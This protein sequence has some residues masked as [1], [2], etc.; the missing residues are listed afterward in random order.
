MPNVHLHG[1]QADIYRFMYKSHVVI[2]PSFSEGTPRSLVEAMASARPVI[3][4]KVGGIPFIVSNDS[5]GYLVPPG[6]SYS[7]SRAIKMFL[8]NPHSVCDF[9]LRARTL[10]LERHDIKKHFS[11][12]RVF[13]AR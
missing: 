2:L 6:D 12:L 1:Y 9:G 7:L 8:E 3:S 13:L 4:T 10:A 11:S 5:T